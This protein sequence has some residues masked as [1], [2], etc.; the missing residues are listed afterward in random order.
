M[1]TTPAVDRSH[2]C[3]FTFPTGRRCRIPLSRSHPYLCTFHARKDAKARAIEKAGRDIAF[4][5]SGRYVSACDF[6]SALAH[7]I[8]AVAQRTITPRAASSIAYLSQ[9]LV[10]S[11]GD[12]ES[13]YMR[14][15]GVDAWK[16]QVAGNF[17]SPRPEERDPSPAPDPRPSPSLHAQQQP[18]DAES[19]DPRPQES[20]N[21]HPGDPESVLE[22]EAASS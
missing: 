20:E 4:D 18:N 12:A 14:V 10:Q 15:F 16:R 3:S 1:S 11:I 2:L 19:G 6:S 8:T 7:C 5:L 17:P 22:P 9:T 13:E 21:E